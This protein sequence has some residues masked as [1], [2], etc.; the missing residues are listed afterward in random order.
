MSEEQLHY[1]RNALMKNLDTRDDTAS[2]TMLLEQDCSTVIPT[3]ITHFITPFIGNA[4]WERIRER[5]R[6]MLE[7]EW[8][9]TDDLGGGR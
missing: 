8:V 4:I 2:S 1:F 3:A 9:P 6:R 7:A 5:G